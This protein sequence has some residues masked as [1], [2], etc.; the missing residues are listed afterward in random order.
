MGQL[1]GGVAGADFGNCRED[2]AGDDDACELRVVRHMIEP[3]G[4]QRVTVHI[5]AELPTEE[6]QTDSKDDRQ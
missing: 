6:R 1:K 3:G 2:G 4:G 5:Q